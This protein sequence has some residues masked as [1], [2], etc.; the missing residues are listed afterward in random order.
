MRYGGHALT[1]AIVDRIFEHGKRPF[2]RI[3]SLS[4]DEKSRSLNYEDFI[5]FMLSE[6]DKG[7]TTS[8]RYWFDL[9]DVNEDDVIRCDEMRFFYHQ[10][11][12]RMECLGHEVVPFEDIVC[13][14]YVDRPCLLIILMIL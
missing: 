7:N 4:P 1:R 2:G 13:Q 10:Q 8:L 11:M 3:Q 6:E 12:H 5:Y 14:L 9:I